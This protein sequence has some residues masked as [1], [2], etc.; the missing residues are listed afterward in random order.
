[1][2]LKLARLLWL[3]LVLLAWRLHARL[4]TG[5]GCSRAAWRSAGRGRRIQ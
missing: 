2:G 3:A 1:M 4:T 5:G